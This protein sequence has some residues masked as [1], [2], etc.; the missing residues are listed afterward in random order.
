M[1]LVCANAISDEYAV[2]GIDLPH[3]NTYWKIQAINSGDFPVISSDPKV[4]EFYDLSRNKGNLYATYDPYVFTLADYVVVD[5][6]LDVRKESSDI[7]ELINYDVDISNFKS[8]I[9]TIGRNCKQDICILIETTVPPGTTNLAS[10]IIKRSFQKEIFQIIILLLV[11]HT[12]R[13]MPGPN[14]IDSIQNFYRV[15]S[16]INA[17]SE[18]AVENFLRT[19]IKTDKYP[20]TKLNNTN[21]TEISKVLENSYRAMNISF[22]VEWSRF[23]EEAGVNLY[24]IIDA[25]RMRDTH[26]NI[27]LPGLG[28][29]GYCLTKDPLLVAGR[30]KI[31]LVQTISHL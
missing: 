22:V 12:K 2:I 29:G 4:K 30:N 27:M 7:N 15:F 13:V 10:K 20:L 21:A 31:S 25:I 1:S 11:I 19:I 14:Y 8:A 16:G 6:N 23:A 26:K 9:K 24:E 5:I 18:L 17:E 28:V 3:P